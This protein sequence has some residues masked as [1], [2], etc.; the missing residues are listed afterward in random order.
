MITLV[1]GPLF[2]R[3][4]HRFHLAW[5]HSLMEM[6]G[7][8]QRQ[9]HPWH[10]FC[11]SKTCLQYRFVWTKVNPNR[12][13]DYLLIFTTVSLFISFIFA[14]I[15]SWISTATP[16]WGLVLFNGS[17]LLL[18]VLN[19]FQ[20]I[21]HQGSNFFLLKPIPSSTIRK[22]SCF[23]SWCK[24]TSICW[25]LC[26]SCITGQFWTIRNRDV[27]PFLLNSQCHYNGDNC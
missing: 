6:S 2:R 21:T 13:F 12:S 4:S 1:S 18:H 23:P 7:L 9:V 11:A 24:K 8:L 26:V 3:L 10:P 20:P 5:H 16:F 27:L 22:W 25:A 17:P 14:K 15:N 19:I